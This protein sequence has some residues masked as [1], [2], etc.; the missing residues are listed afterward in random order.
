MTAGRRMK[1]E[2]MQAER[3]RRN[4]GRPAPTL[5]ERM[6]QDGVSDK[7]RAEVHRFAAYLADSKLPLMERIEKHGADYLGF[8]PEEVE[9]VRAAASGG[10]C[11]P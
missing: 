8:T 3:K 6:K 9:V 10:K 7:D 4:I 1:H 5:D 2:M 11:S